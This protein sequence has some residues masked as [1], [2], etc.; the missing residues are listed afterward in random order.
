[1]SLGHPWSTRVDHIK[2]SPIVLHPAVWY[3]A[4]SHIGFGYGANGAMAPMT[5]VRM[6][7]TAPWRQCMAPLQKSKG[8][9]AFRDIQARPL[10]GPPPALGGGGIA[11]FLTKEILPMYHSIHC[12]LHLKHLFNMSNT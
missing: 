10:E 5:P 8:N 12:F 9:K 1:M 4:R 2:V 3:G 7:P 11:S 6:A